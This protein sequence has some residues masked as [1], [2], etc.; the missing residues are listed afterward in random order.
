MAANEE[1]RNF[2][3]ANF[4]IRSSL[5]WWHQR[6]ELSKHR[7]LFDTIESQPLTDL[8]RRSVILNEQRNLVV[9]GA[10]TG[11]T[12][13]IVAK[14]GYL[15]KS[16]KC[17]PEDI[18]LLAF[19]NNAAREL[20]DR[21]RDRLG[22]EVKA[23]TFHALGNQI[24]GE[25]ENPIPSVSKLATDRL[26]F[27]KFVQSAISELR[28]DPIPWKKLRSFILGKL[29]PYKPETEFKTI[30]EYKAYTRSVELRTLSGEL[31]KSF[32]E[33]DIANFLYLKGVKYEYEPR[34][35]NINKR[36]Q[37]DFFLPDYDIYIEHFG[38]DRN[39][40]T[41][42][43]IDSERYSQGMAWKRQIHARNHTNL[44]ET[45]SWQKS[46]GDL[47]KALDGHLKKASVIY[48]PLPDDEI[49]DALKKM[50]YISQLGKLIEAFLAHFKSNQLT[51][52]RI[53]TLASGS[54]SPD[55]GLS[56]VE[57]FSYFYSRYEVELSNPPTEI[58]FN[59][60]ISKSTKYVETGKFQA[61]WKYIIVDEFQD[62]SVG[63]YLLIDA[64]LRRR[65]DLQFFAVGDDWQS[66]NRFAGSDISIMNRFRDYFGK[67]TVVKLDKTFRFNDQIASVSGGFIQKN[68][69]QIRKTLTTE[70]TAA[71]PQV[72]LHW[73][74]RNWDDDS[75][76]AT[77]L[78]DA[79]SRIESQS[80]KSSSLQI[81]ARYNYL[82][83][84]PNIM[85]SVSDC[86]PG[87][88]LDPRTVHRSKGL[89]A[90]FVVLIGLSAD[91][92]GFPSEIEDD[93]LLDLVLAEPDS[94]PHA[95]ERRLF[96]VAATRAKRQVHFLVDRDH[97]S[98]FADELLD[99]E[100]NILHIGRSEENDEKCPECKTGLIEEK[101]PNFFGCSNFP[102]CEYVAPLC[103]EC[104]QEHMVPPNH[105]DRS[106]YNCLD[107]ECDGMAE[108]CPICGV[109]AV[110]SK[111]GR[112]GEFLGCHIWPRCNFTQNISKDLAR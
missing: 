107:N 97:P 106:D 24:L 50:G 26:Q 68:P 33:L 95:E 5:F 30:E 99:G 98:A 86:W 111:T 59:D 7:N 36:Y 103:D 15:I 63:R 64:M 17:K 96:Y 89:E 73:Q 22:E 72:V 41:A 77:E 23:S 75:P 92:L 76:Y 70:T 6:R 21:C 1:V 94:Y 37:P 79:I 11:K 69:K 3:S 52:D 108:V 31:V 100:Y 109:G 20:E 29:K 105:S 83:P 62:I 48:S 2:I 10:G 45:Y 81:L 47:L 4:N 55:R 32:A 42:A 9:A 61:P 39:G 12:S 43:Y 51:I 102:F 18:L 90:D 57:V 27:E 88:V 60:M 112:Y 28:Q 35:P 66:I 19:N 93:P 110:I 74:K 46:E 53:S 67:A 84:N 49:F 71:S 104:T 25:I 54:A 13:V 56:F 65:E 101:A 44:V 85:R 78:L 58:D 82:L 80:T 87:R 38:I 16:G 34:Y 40:E 8:Q 91:K 14:V